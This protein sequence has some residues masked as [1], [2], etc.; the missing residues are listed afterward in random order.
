MDLLDEDF[1]IGDFNVEDYLPQNGRRRWS[2]F[3]ITINT[4]QNIGQLGGWQAARAG[5]A[6]ITTAVEDTI[7]NWQAW[8][9]EF[10]DGQQVPIANAAVIHN[11][12]AR[13]ALERGGNNNQLHAHIV[14]EVEHDTRVQ[15]DREQLINAWR[16]AYAQPGSVYIRLLTEQEDLGFLLDYILKQ[17]LPPNAISDANQRLL[18]VLNQG[19]QEVAIPLYDEE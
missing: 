10:V 14:L 6:G 4:N 5:L 7:D 2:N 11:I 1:G 9:M 17:G 18:R 12:R 19:A 8:L 13:V 3:H 16:Q 15:I